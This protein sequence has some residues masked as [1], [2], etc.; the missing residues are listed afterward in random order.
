M[1]SEEEDLNPPITLHLKA[2]S[3][4]SDIACRANDTVSSLKESVIR[5]LSAHG[6]NVRLIHAGKMLDDDENLLSKYGIADGSFIHAVVTSIQGS[7]S[8][9]QLHSSAPSVPVSSYRGFDRLAVLGLSLDETA[10]LRSSFNPQVNQFIASNSYQARQGE[11]NTTFRYRM[12]EEWI[13]SQGTRS[14]FS[15]NLPADNR[16]RLAS[17]YRQGSSD[18][19]YPMSMATFSFATDRRRGGD[20]SFERPSNPGTMND[21]FWGMAMG[22]GLGILMLFC[23]WDRNISQKQKYGILTGVFLHLL[24]GLMQQSFDQQRSNH[25]AD[26]ALMAQNPTELIFDENK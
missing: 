24:F 2:S 25:R 23:V 9:P 4:D 5:I 19:D 26:Q 1:R 6:K 3:G 15:M 7:G 8:S 12:E 17:T 18:S 10:A 21:F 13:A 14:E 20:V 22:F 11:D 16:N